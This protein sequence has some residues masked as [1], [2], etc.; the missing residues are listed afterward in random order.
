MCGD[1]GADQACEAQ[2]R[3]CMLSM[4]ILMWSKGST[5]AQG[6]TGRAGDTH[7]TRTLGVQARPPH[8]PM[9]L[10][11][12]GPALPCQVLI[13]ALMA[14]MCLSAGQNGQQ[15]G[16]QLISLFSWIVLHA[17]PPSLAPSHLLMLCYVLACRERQMRGPDGAG[18]ARTKSSKLPCAAPSQM[19]RQDFWGTPQRQATLMTSC[20]AAK[21]IRYGSLTKGARCIAQL[22][23]QCTCHNAAR[24]LSRSLL[25]PP[26]PMRRALLL[27]ICTHAHP[28]APSLL[29]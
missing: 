18:M 12:R 3:V 27:P 4:S 5:R 23:V 29:C 15:E 6:G 1:T 17:Q 10:W 16:N 14:H 21:M 2:T 7:V 22:G 28:A 20:C 8:V 24:L 25:P 19:M 13:V 9:R 26:L 11:P